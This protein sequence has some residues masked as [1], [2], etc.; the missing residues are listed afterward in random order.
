MLTSGMGRVSP[1]GAGT[2]GS[3]RTVVGPA[4]DVKGSADGRAEGGVPAT[5]DGDCGEG[6]S[7]AAVSC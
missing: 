6:G 7:V 4:G 2:S 1:N 5:D 3:G